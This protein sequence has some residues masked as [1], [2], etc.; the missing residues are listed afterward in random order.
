MGGRWDFSVPFYFYF[1]FG[2]HPPSLYSPRHHSSSEGYIHP[3]DWNF[4]SPLSLKKNHFPTARSLSWSEH[5]TFGLWWD[6]KRKSGEIV[7]SLSEG[8]GIEIY[9]RE[10]EEGWNGV[11]GEGRAGVGH[12]PTLMLHWNKY[13]FKMMLFRWLCLSRMKADILIFTSSLTGGQPHCNTLNTMPAQ[14]HRMHVQIYQRE[15]CWF[16]GGKLR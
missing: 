1:I 11:L 6:I 5:H 9:K 7:L 16:V 15:V 13:I 12:A 3:I 14:T 8:N 4:L 2:V 10:N